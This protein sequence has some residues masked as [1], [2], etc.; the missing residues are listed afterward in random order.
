MILHIVTD[1]GSVKLWKD[2]E[3]IGEIQPA[4]ALGLAADITKAM[5]DRV[6]KR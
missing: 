6:V 3:M 1:K 2:G 5:A 4:Q